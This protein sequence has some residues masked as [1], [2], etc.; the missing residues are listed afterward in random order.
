MLR[1]EADSRALQSPSGI[2][3]PASGIRHPASG[4]RHP[5]KCGFIIKKSIGGKYPFVSTIIPLAPATTVELTA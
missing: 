4:I 1:G 5:A 3:H 2:R